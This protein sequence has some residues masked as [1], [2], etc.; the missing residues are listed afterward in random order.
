VTN[1]ENQI[2]QINDKIEEL[3]LKRIEMIRKYVLPFVEKV[4][5]KLND[6][7][8][9]KFNVIEHYFDEADELFVIRVKIYDEKFESRLQKKHRI[10]DLMHSVVNDEFAIKRIRFLGA[11]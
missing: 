3:R 5:N 9:F 8:D 2:K 11:I 6:F 1:I 7:H 10:I 4:I